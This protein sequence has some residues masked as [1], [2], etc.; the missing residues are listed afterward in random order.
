MMTFGRL[1]FP[2]DDR[3]LSVVFH[4]FKIHSP[5]Y[6]ILP[7]RGSARLCFIR[8]DTVMIIFGVR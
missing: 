8:S 1:R 2:D 7:V 6:H 5:I 3:T 4:G